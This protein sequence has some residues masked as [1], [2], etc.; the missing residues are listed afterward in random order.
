MYAEAMTKTPT[1]TGRAIIYTRVSTAAQAS[2]GMSLTAQ[3]DKLAEAAEAAGFNE[4]ELV[5]EAGRSGRSI[6]GRPALKGALADLKAGRADAL[7]I[8]KLDR[9]ARNAKDALTVVNLA[10]QQGW[11]LIVLDLQLDTGTIAGRLVFTMLA[12]VAEM[13]YGLI[14]E[15]QTESHAERRRQGQVWGVTHGPRSDMPAELRHR[16]VEARQAGQSLR[17]IADALNAE[18]VPA[19]KGGR[20]YAST[21]KAVVESPASAGLVPA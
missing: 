16:I 2:D 1:T 9:L 5:V 4:S 12:A 18:G 15:R 10:E 8:A 17:A 6:T 7:I 11:R 20:W 21:I 13:E 14:S 3:A 19:M